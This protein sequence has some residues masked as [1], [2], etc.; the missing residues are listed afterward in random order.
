[1]D[2]SW[3]EIV[4]VILLP[5]KRFLTSRLS[6]PPTLKPLL[7]KEQANFEWRDAP[8]GP[9]LEM[10]IWTSSE[11]MRAEIKNIYS[12]DI[13]D[14]ERYRPEHAESFSFH[15][16]LIAGPQ[17][18]AGEESFDLRVCTPQWLL[19]NH[20]KDDVI[21]GRHY[22]IVMEYNYE[23]ILK[24]ITDFCDTC[25]GTTWTEV[26]QKLGRLGHWEF[27]DYRETLQ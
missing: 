23:R 24:T 13:D 8:G 7:G 18:E 11:R 15:L 3:I 16:R 19:D 14:L 26:A 20:R 27:E 4:L 21:I 5:H 2:S 10:V 1:M 22:L 12:F 25:E 6:R 9:P 17:N